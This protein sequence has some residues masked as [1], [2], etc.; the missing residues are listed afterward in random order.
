MKRLVK[1]LKTLFWL[2]VCLFVL[3]MMLLAI[4]VGFCW[5]M[6]TIGFAGGVCAGDEFIEFIHKKVKDVRDDAD[7]S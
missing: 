6:I 1:G 3:A 4:L 7:K 2:L 5:T